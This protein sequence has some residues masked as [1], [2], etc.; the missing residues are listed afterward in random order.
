MISADPAEHTSSATPK[1]RVTLRISRVP[2]VFGCTVWKE[3]G[4]WPKTWEYLWDLRGGAEGSGDYPLLY[5]NVQNDSAL[6]WF[7]E[8]LIS[9]FNFSDQVLCCR[10]DLAFLYTADAAL[11]NVL[12]CCGK[13]CL[14]TFDFFY[15]RLDVSGINFLFYAASK[16]FRFIF[17][18]FFLLHHKI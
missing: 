17:F 3:P 7:V 10:S 4:S 8:D 9:R 6:I 1:S 13:F 5:R 15:L 18:F 11:I 16:Y 14:Y 2:T 12:T